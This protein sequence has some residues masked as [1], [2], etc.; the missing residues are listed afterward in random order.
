MAGTFTQ[1]SSEVITT[2][3]ENYLTKLQLMKT[4][5]SYL[6]AVSAL[7][8]FSA[9]A[10][11]QIEDTEE[12][13]AFISQEVPV[14]ESILPT[15]RPFNSV[16]GTD[17]SILETPRNVT[18]IS[19]EQ[20]D[21]ISIKT[22]RDFARLTS[23]SYTKSNFGAPTSPNLRGQEADM[24]VNGIRKG[25]TSNGNGLPINFNAVESVNI[26]KGPAGPVYG[27]SNYLG[28]FA[29]LITKRAYFDEA[30]GYM[31]ATVGSYDVRYWQVDY[32]TPISEELAFRISYSGEDSKGYY[33]NGKKKTQAIYS[34]FTFR[35]NDKYEL[36]VAGEFFVAD[37]TENWGI[38]RPT[39]Q[40]IDDGLYIPNAQTDEE[41]YE[42]ISK[43]GN[44][45]SIFSGGTPGVDFASI[46]GG[47]GF[48]TISPLDTANPVKI[49]RSVRL[50][51]PGDDSFGKNFW[52]Q[53]VQTFTLSEDVKIENNSYYQWIDRNTFSSYN[54]SEL[55][56]DN[57][58]FDN[59]LMLVVEKEDYDLNAGLR[60]RW[61]H[62][63]SVNHYYNE[64]V[65]F[66]DLT[67]SFDGTNNGRV[68]DAGFAG[69]PYVPDEEA[70]GIL[71]KYY[72]GGTGGDADGYIVGPFVQFTAKAIDNLI[73]DLGVGL[74]YVDATEVH[75]IIGASGFYDFN[76]DGDYDD[77]YEQGYEIS[78]SLSLW[79][80]QASIS[81]LLNDSTTLYATYGYSQTTPADTGGRF[82]V[83]GFDAEQES[84]LFEVGAKFQLMENK[85]FLGTAIVDRAFTVGN[86]DGSTDDVEITAFEIELNYQP[87][88]QFYATFGYSFLDAKRTAGFFATGYTADRADETGGYFIAPTFASPSNGDMMLKYPGTPE[89]Q[90]VALASYKFTESW[91]V[92]GN[93][94]MTGPMN[95]GYE[96]FEISIFNAEDFSNPYTLIASTVELPW[97][98]EIDLTVFYEMEDW[99]FKLT[100]FNLTDEKN[101]DAPNAGYGNG[102]VIAREPIRAEFTV[103]YQF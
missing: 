58:S 4:R 48:A 22:P 95:L 56:R 41:Y 35:P 94:V 34:T 72:Y 2:T 70:R 12:L 18:I 103:R 16:F 26:V 96:G 55:L 85:L 91:G 32:S 3:P 44:G 84:E 75:P 21:A 25:L 79:N 101:W 28:G 64:P 81:Y 87:N 40:L 10:Q 19:R 68:P 82:D 60:Y 83:G 20:L 45:V 27:T 80:Y 89:H 30:R 92:R 23:S 76:E 65:N 14:E 17:R 49:D 33:Q 42:Y 97:Q 71:E 99:D 69:Y 37:Y 63:W 98:Y 90:F 52:A 93:F 88:Q 73:I 13:D 61:E 51:A 36:F 7:A 5:T 11:A 62:V 74:D 102:S 39:Q 38:N 6:L 43:L 15:T 54:Y 53:A 78:D 24:F 1:A 66:W 8:L 29:D 59:R 31:T 86:P 57:W 46:F 50:L 77:D 67:R 47:A 100:V 9:N